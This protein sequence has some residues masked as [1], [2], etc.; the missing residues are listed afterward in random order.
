MPNPRLNIGPLKTSRELSSLL[1]ILAPTF[2]FTREQGQRY[3]KFVGRTNYRVVRKGGEVIGGC[4]LLP[5]GQFFGGRSVPMMGV[6]AVGIAPE[7]RGQQAASTMMQSAVKEMHQRGFPISVL[8]PATLPIYRSVGYELAG[9]RYEIR[10]PAKSLNFKGLDR[11]AA[12]EMRRITD[13]DNAGIE[14]CYNSRAVA[15]S[16]NVDRSVFLWHRTRLP[17]GQATLGFAVIN[18]KTK[19]IEGYTRY[20]QKEAL[21]APYSLHLTDLV[22]LTPAAGRRLLSFFADHRS[23]THEI[24]FYGTPDDPIIKLLP[25]HPYFARLF[26]HWMIRIVDVPGAIT[27]RGYADAVDGEAHV[28]IADDLLAENDDSFVITIQKGRAKVKRGG[29]G[30][31]RIDV[32]GLGALYTGH[33]SPSDLQITGQMDWTR[34]GEASAATLAAAFAGPAPWMPDMF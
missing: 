16:G 6:G 9:V 17:R 1:D 26:M 7:H 3:T 10:I 25:D 11:G 15:T 22:A 23:M 29:R 2:N 14:K 8:Y 18:P 12:L 19:L 20:L 21:E 32:R 24:Q 13:R 28:R 4:A 27:A 30:D 31:V 34:R 5:M 33:M